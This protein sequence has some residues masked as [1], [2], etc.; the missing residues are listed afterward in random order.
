MNEPGKSKA[1]PPAGTVS[2]IAKPAVP[3]NKKIAAASPTEAPKPALLTVDKA[4]TPTPSSIPQPAP[5]L[6]EKIATA[7]PV[8][9]SVSL[10]PIR[11][12]IISALALP[13]S[14]P[15]PQA[16]AGEELLA[17]YRA[18]LMSVGESQRAV[19]SGITALTLEVTGLARA[20][21]TEAAQSAAAMARAR[22]LAE[23]VEI[24][25]SYA[26]RSLAAIIAGSTRLSEIGSTLLGEASRPIVAPFAQ[27]SHG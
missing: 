23:V 9:A 26:Q 6:P 8:V 12:K 18:T 25:F 3:P 7:T 17:T 1:K 13:R 2:G 10:P 14:V 19:A 27:R 5:E 21:A 11:E 4:A 22:N 20:T 24:Q 16:I 15:K